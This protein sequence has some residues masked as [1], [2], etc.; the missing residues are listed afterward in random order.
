MA[1][2]LV[3]QAGVRMIDLIYKIGQLQLEMMNILVN[4]YAKA[5]FFALL[6]GVV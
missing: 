2:D 1:A 4:Y 5:L 6:G 3:A